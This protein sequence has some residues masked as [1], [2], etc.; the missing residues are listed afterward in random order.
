MYYLSAIFPG[1]DVF[2][3][4][5]TDYSLGLKN[6]H[7]RLISINAAQT[8]SLD[9]NN[10]NY[11]KNTYNKTYSDEDMFIMYE[12]RNKRMDLCMS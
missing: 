11:T 3:N 10:Y 5:S 8:R 9:K 7:M 6:M 2:K 4:I 12:D 1:Y